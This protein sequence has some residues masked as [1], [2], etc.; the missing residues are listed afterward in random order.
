MRCLEL[1][2]LGARLNTCDISQ[3]WGVCAFYACV[4]FGGPGTLRCVTEQP[5]NGKDPFAPI[6]LNTATQTRLP[7][8]EIIQREKERDGSYLGA[9]AFC[10][11][12]C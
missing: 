10:K 6:E 2:A 4:C 9:N 5:P 3:S 11:S 1:W 7:R 8:S 12:V